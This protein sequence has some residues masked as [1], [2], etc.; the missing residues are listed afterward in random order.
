MNP[1]L[2]L[3]HPAEGESFRVADRRIAGAILLLGML[4]C[5]GAVAVLG[6]DGG[7]DLRNY[8]WY[9]P[10]ALLNGRL[11]F[12]VLPSFMGPTFHNPLVD[13]PFYLTVKGLG[14]LWA[15]LG[16]GLVHG[17]NVLP[18]YAI[19]RRVLP[20]VGRPVAALLAVVGIAGAMNISLLGA[21]AGDNIL[22]LFALGAIAAFLSVQQRGVKALALAGLLAGAGFGLKPVLAPFIV[23]LTVGVVAFHTFRAS[24]ARALLVFALAGI[25][26]TLLTGGFWMARLYAEFGN[27]LMPY[28]NDIFAAAY[29]P[30]H[31]YSDPGFTANL[32]WPRVQLP[33]LA[34]IVDHVSAEASFTDWRIPLGYGGALALLLAGLVSRAQ[35]ATAGFRLCLI[36]VATL[37][38]WSIVFAIYRYVLAVEMLGPILVTLALL[39]LIPW[40]RA[41]SVAAAIVLVAIV[42]VT[43]PPAAERV[44]FAAD[45]TG[46]EVPAIT[47]PERAVVLMVGLTPS[48]FVIPSFPPSVRFLRFDGFWIDPAERAAGYAQE[49]RRAV[50]QAGGAVSILFEPGEAARVTEG[51]KAFDPTLA[52]GACRPLHHHLEQPGTNWGSFVLCDV[53]GPS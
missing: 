25:T 34:G 13:V 12:D 53:N 27:P 35:R 30:A 16:L 44:A 23:G 5:A 50:A 2:R 10:Y 26:G 4:A 32:P 18:L 52:I 45:L 22:S 38:P 37:A 14:P 29:V 40:P 21:T 43:R 11:G 20:Q 51:L 3:R 19:A 9:V 46:V 41:A 42:A 47:Q 48:A 8:H 15:S 6:Q 39:R 31:T 33:F 49:I 28:F 17:A 1:V 7:W 24:G 36:V